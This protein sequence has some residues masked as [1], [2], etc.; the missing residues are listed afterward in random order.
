[1]DE[2][3][4]GGVDGAAEAE[5]GVDPMAISIMSEGYFNSKRRGERVIGRRGTSCQHS[6]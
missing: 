4:V 1:M 6:L 3:G 5:G 2:E